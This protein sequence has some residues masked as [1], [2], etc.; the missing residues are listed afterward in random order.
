MVGIVEAGA[1]LNGIKTAFGIAKGIS[2]LKSEADINLAVIEIQRALLDAQE[3]AFRDKE[4]IST[5]MGRVDELETAAKA[6]QGWEQERARYQL[7]QS[8]I[9]AFT[10]VLK[11]EHAGGEPTHRLCATCFDKGHKSVLHTT[12]K[13]NGGEVVWC[14]NCKE[15]LKLAEFNNPV[16]VMRRPNSRW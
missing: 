13:G 3:A 2:A 14:G 15:K 1:A 5:L 8:P 9:G 6:G 11:D 4:T 10:Y 12:R 7:E 16:V